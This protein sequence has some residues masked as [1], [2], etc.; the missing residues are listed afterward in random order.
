MYL[1][2]ANEVGVATAS[3]E[4]MRI[5]SSGRLLVNTATALSNVYVGASANAPIFQV[6]GN[7]GSS[8]ALSITRRTGASA[9]LFIQ[10]GATGT[11]VSNGNPLGRIVFNGSDGT[12]Y[13]NAS[14]IY[15]EVDNVPGAADMP[16][17]LV[18]A[19]SSLGSA[20]PTERMRIDSSGF[21][22]LAADTNTGFSNPSADNLA[23]TTGGSER[24]RVDDG[25][26]LLIGTS[27]ALANVYVGP[28]ALA[29]S[30]QIEGNIG[31]RSALSI[32]RQTGAAANIVLQRGVTGTPVVT[33][34][35]VGQVV[36]NGF[37]G[38]NFRNTAS[39]ISAVD[40]VAGIDVMPGRLAF[41]T[42]PDGAA[43]PAERMRIDRSG[44]L[45]VGTTTALDNVY[46]IG[47]AVSPAV[48]V[49]GNTGGSASLSITRQTGAAAN[50]FLQRGVAGTPVVANDI[51]GQFVFNGFDGASFRNAAAMNV[52]V[53]GTPGLDD[54]PGRLVLA[55]TPAG[56]TLPVERM[57]IKSTGV[58][59]FASCPTYAD[60]AAAGTGGLVS[61]DIYKT[62]TGELRI[63]L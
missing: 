41:A 22:S 17:R 8:A 18:F 53:D 45:L 46:V 51:L 61:G 29:P 26:R 5:D 25:G 9:T 11:P 19:T 60:D 40:G 36:F 15:G 6:E 59:N 2:A 56:A 33:G 31:S 12:D 38:T 50:L 37:D 3:T 63:K 58:I 27:S 24:A 20:T 42:T 43:T 30:L 14:S 44:R 54:M 52:V 23:V 28:A 7:T 4:R 32:T 1:P 16:G 57:R 21:V 55:T 35:P 47:T 48:Q 49:E 62:A 13:R 10:R 39:I 34:D